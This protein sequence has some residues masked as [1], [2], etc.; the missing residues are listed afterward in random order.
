MWHS[1][2]E[3]WLRDEGTARGTEGSAARW[4]EHKRREEMS[5]GVK[6]GGKK[7]AA[8]EQM[9]RIIVWVFLTCDWVLRG[10]QALSHL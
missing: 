6:G 2:R 4:G 5:E 7:A 3:P 1:G 8:E 10:Q 9:P